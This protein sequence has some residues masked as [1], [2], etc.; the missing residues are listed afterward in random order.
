MLTALCNL[1]RW[2][3]RRRSGGLA[4]EEIIIVVPDQ[5]SM[6]SQNFSYKHTQTCTTYI[7]ILLHSFRFSPVFTA[8]W[9]S[10]TSTTGRPRQLR[11]A[12]VKSVRTLS[13]ASQKQSAKILPSLSSLEQR[14][15]KSSGLVELF[16]LLAP[17]SRP[18][19]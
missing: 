17:R 10:T 9:W 8:V 4:V 13:R 6:S 19:E 2:L 1:L 5:E 14:G 15:L 7:F 12:R 11:P 3:R 18:Q 16:R